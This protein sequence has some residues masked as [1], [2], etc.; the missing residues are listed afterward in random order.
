MQQGA[1]KWEDLVC[2][3]GNPCCQKLHSE[4]QRDGRTV[5]NGSRRVKAFCESVKRLRLVVG[6]LRGKGV[7]DGVVFEVRVPQW[8]FGYNLDGLR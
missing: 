8:V 5:T 3:A 6:L 1:A 2:R 4:V 7:M